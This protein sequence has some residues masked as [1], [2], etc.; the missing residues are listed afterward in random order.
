MSHVVVVASGGLDSTAA[1]ALHHA[2]GDTIT[3]VTV[4][5]GQR[6][7]REIRAARNVAAHY[8]IDHVIVDLADLGQVLTGS[9]LTD[10]SVPVPHGHYAAP[11]M[12]ATVVPNRNAILANVA[13]GVAVARKAD[14]VVLG[15][16]AGDHPIYP[17]CRPVFVDALAACVQ[18]ATDGYH[19]PRVEAPF[20]WW[21]KTAIARFAA[22][23]A[24]PI[25]LT[26][27]CYEGGDV[28][29]GRCGTCV[30]RREALRDAGVADP[31][32]YLP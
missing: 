6:H 1:I 28:H 24:A 32:P 30:E 22:R 26:W 17:D 25:D 8:L 9:A 2:A 12:A 11:A 16:H 7:V 15:I 18:V 31:T 3:A 23:L 5:Y 20:V 29:C 13:V 4:N 14:A 10:P 27:S 19:T 21:T